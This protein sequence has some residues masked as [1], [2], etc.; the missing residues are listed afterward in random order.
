MEHHGAAGALERHHFMTIPSVNWHKVGA[1]VEF[2]RIIAIE[3]VYA[4][5]SLVG[6]PIEQ[7]TAAEV[8]CRSYHGG[9]F[10]ARV[11]MP[12]RMVIG[13]DAKASE[14]HD[15][16]VVLDYIVPKNKNRKPSIK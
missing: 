16:E 14:G 11:S 9:P 2:L 4:N 13:V 1:D 12:R 15:I 7:S 10:I 8:A 5:S 6:W 3:L